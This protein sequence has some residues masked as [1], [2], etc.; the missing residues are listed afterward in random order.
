MVIL[1][2]KQYIENKEKIDELFSFII[3][4]ADL[5]D[6]SDNK[7]IECDEVCKENLDRS[8][9]KMLN[10][11]GY[12]IFQKEDDISIIYVDFG[13]AENK[14]IYINNKEFFDCK[15]LILVAR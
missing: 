14:V 11:L 1:D 4:E 5:V 2:E 3:N 8:I 7:E 10:N 12:T 13:K 15:E 9:F 6:I